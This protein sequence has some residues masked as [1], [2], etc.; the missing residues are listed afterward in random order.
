MTALES[1]G[2]IQD[3]NIL[4]LQTTVSTLT[5]N[6]SLTDVDVTGLIADKILK[7]DGTKW[8]VSDDANGIADVPNDSQHYVRN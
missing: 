4:N 7:Y 6:H 1:N 3:T 5:L 2:A 8:I